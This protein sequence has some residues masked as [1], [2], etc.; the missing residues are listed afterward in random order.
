MAA[1]IAVS[2]VATMG[3]LG[4]SRSKMV[5]RPTIVQMISTEVP[6]IVAEAGKD[7]LTARTKMKVLYRRDGLHAGADFVA[8]AKVIGNSNDKNDLMLAHDLAI[9]GLALGD[10]SAKSVVAETEDR[11]FVKV[12]LGERFGTQGGGSLPLTERHRSL[13]CGAPVSALRL[14]A[15]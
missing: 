2:M 5:A 4:A 1:G 11:L 9:A 14:S 8:A 6:P 10:P 3:L 7:P 12:G 13:L 15:E